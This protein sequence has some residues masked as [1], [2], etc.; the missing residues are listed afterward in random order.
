GLY[1]PDSGRITLD[2]IDIREIKPETLRKRIGVVL[3]QP[4]LFQDTVRGNIARGMPGASPHEVVMAA[5]RAGAH[6]FIASLPQGYETPVDANGAN[7]SAGQ[8]QRIMIAQVLLRDPEILVL[9]EATSAIDQEADRFLL[10]NLDG[11]FK[12]RTTILVSARR[13]TV[14]AA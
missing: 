14:E 8:R 6:D 1:Q 13:R 2:G 9:D 3:Q 11:M 10:H 5:R 12:G 7:L 4:F